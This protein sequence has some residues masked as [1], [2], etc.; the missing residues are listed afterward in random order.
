MQGK[1][2]PQFPWLSSTLSFQKSQGNPQTR[3]AR[4]GYL[5][6]NPGA[7]AAWGLDMADMAPLEIPQA[8]A[9]GDPDGV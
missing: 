5:T 6:C 9:F 2:V 4:S 3:S 7:V 1:K 8:G